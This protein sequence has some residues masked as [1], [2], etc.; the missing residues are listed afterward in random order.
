MPSFRLQNWNGY[1]VKIMPQDSTRLFFRFIPYF[2]GPICFDVSIWVPKNKN[3]KNEMIGYEWVLCRSKDDTTVKKGKGTIRFAEAK[4]YDSRKVKNGDMVR[5]T[6]TKFSRI[7]GVDLEHMSIL[8]QYKILM[9]FSDSAGN[10]SEFMIMMEFTLE[11]RDHYSLNV[12]SA[13][14]GAVA[15]AIAGG[16]VALLVTM[17]TKGQ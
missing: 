4:Q 1:Q 14:L 10:S 11:D 15:G 9:S 3:V 6:K 12:V 8:D 16:L 5:Q 17:F 13:L 2:Y 7:G